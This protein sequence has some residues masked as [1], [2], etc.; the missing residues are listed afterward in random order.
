MDICKSQ[1]LSPKG[2]V[3]LIIKT[4]KQQ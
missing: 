4:A 3:Q 2:H 1:D